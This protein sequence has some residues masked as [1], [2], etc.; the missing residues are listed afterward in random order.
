MRRLPPVLAG[1]AVA[2]AV[3]VVAERVVAARTGPL[4]LVGVFEV[5]LLARSRL[6]RGHGDRRV[7]ARR[8]AAAWTRLAG[9][10]VVVL[11]VVALGGELWSPA[12][13]AA[14]R[15][16]LAPG[17]PV[18]EPGARARRRRADSVAGIRAIDADVVA[19]QELTP[20]AAAAI[21]ADPILRERYPY[22]ILEARPGV[23]GLGLLARR[24]LLARGHA[25]EPLVLRAGLL[26][27]DGRTLDVLVVHPYPPGISTLWRLPVGL[28]T[29][30]RD[31]DLVG[32]SR[33]RR[34]A[35]TT[36]RR[37]RGRR[38]QRGRRPSPAFRASTGSPTPTRRPG[39]GRASRG[40]R[41]RS[42]ALGL[43]LLR[44]DH[45]LTGPWLVPEAAATDCTPSATT[46]GSLVTIRVPP[47]A[48]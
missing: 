21:E 37:A 27:A 34:R 24:P 8:P 6:A 47:R 41:A 11:A 44:I 1:L 33:P 30:R 23:D 26:L 43:G 40:G 20:D 48:P 38:P 3:V 36:P 39:P 35:W 16:L 14:R 19:L 45:V 12:P 4:A 18:V 42:E 28:D 25:T 13:A 5:H 32:R 22:R 10:A 46:A 17:R 29:R 31:E 15:G 9:V 2:L 7:A